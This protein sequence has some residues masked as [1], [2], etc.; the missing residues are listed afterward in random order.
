MSSATDYYVYVY[1]DPRNFEEFYFGKGRGS[2]KEAHL[3]D[4]SD[5][6]K[7]KR[8]AAIHEAGLKPIIRVIARELSEHDAL[9]VEKTLLWK[10]G[11]QLTN[12]SSGHYASN[13][14]PHN[15]LHA[16]LTGFDYQCG[17]YYYNVGEGKHR[18]WE[19][20]RTFGFISGGQGK[21]WRD[22][23]L[24]FKKGDVVAAY[25]KG[26]GFVG[27]GKLTSEAKRIR[28]VLIGSKPLLEHELA[29]KNM[30]ENIESVE[31]CEYVATVDWIKHVR[32]DEAKWER[33]SGLYTTTH[34]RASLDGQ[35]ATVAF[36][37]K[38]FD[39]SVREHVE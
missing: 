21:R 4:S 37:V 39:V 13:F 32:C 36:L 2:R 20:Y 11:R 30:G 38:E 25:L 27:I 22:A 26:C 17:F 3:S 6:E 18:N 29:C 14:R 9:L 10:L 24:G 7:A 34:V 5:S 16:Q 1:I 8:I 23:M 12:I 33:N 19:D 31:L 35:P 15:T 28:D